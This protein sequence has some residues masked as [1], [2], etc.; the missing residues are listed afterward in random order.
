[1]FKRLNI[2]LKISLILAFLFLCIFHPTLSFSKE[3]LPP[4]SPFLREIAIKAQKDIN[5]G[6]LKDAEKSLLPF[7]K[8]Q[9]AHPVFCFLIANTY[10]LEK[11]LPLALTFYKKT[12]KLAPGYLP[13]I[14]NAAAVS[15]ELKRYIR[16]ANYYLNAWQI[17]KKQKNPDKKL[18]YNCAIAYYQAHK[19]RKAISILKKLFNISNNPSKASISLYVVCSI[20]LKDYKSCLKKLTQFINKYP[21]KAYLWLYAGQIL[22]LK[23]DYKNAAIYLEIAYTLDNASPKKWK[24]LSNIYAYC[25]APIKAAKCYLRAVPN[26]LSKSDLKTLI[27]Y[28]LQIHNYKIAI[29]YIKEAIKLSQDPSLYI[30]LGKL[31]FEHGQFNQAKNSLKKALILINKKDFKNKITTDK[32]NETW[33]LLGVSAFETQ[34]FNLAQKAFLHLVHIKRYKQQAKGYLAFISLLK[35]TTQNNKRITINGK[36]KDYNPTN[37]T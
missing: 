29:S 22:L 30:L 20:N 6:R 32:I 12:I 23:K 15:F 9:N 19:Y 28:F 37:R 18:L 13:A 1:M 8:G 4:L 24:E 2:K 7:V 16:A 26:K 25:N 3:N 21:Y 35:D 5:S 34:D 27:N 33:M 14:E 11:K 36:K 31:A 17:S 10:Y